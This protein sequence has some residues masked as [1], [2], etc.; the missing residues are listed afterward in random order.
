MPG[1]QPAYTSQVPVALSIVVLALDAL[2]L[3]RRCVESLERS[4]ESEHELILVDNG[5]QDGTR[6]WM[7]GTGHP[8][9][10]HGENLGFAAGMNSGLRRAKGEFVVFANND[11]I[12]PDGWDTSILDVFDRVPTAGIVAPAVT[13]AGNPATVRTQVGDGVKVFEP[14]GHLPS[15]VVYVMR[16]DQARRLGGWNEN[17]LIATGE[18]L[19]LLWTVWANGLDVVLDERILIEHVSEATRRKRTDMEEIRKRNLELFLRRWETSSPPPSRLEECPME[20]FQVNLRHAAAGA[21]W[22]RRLVEARIPKGTSPAPDRS[23]VAPVTKPQRRSLFPRR[24]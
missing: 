23:A 21:I 9:V 22:L 17:Y 11:T 10:L 8:T 20:L 7:A 15:G 16:T 1:A 24:R 2:E 5:S 13:A 14:F 18:D 4:T 12:F 19:D 3:T 6:E